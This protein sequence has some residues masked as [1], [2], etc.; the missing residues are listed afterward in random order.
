[1]NTVT[2]RDRASNTMSAKPNFF[3]LEK[4][5]PSRFNQEPIL[6]YNVSVAIS[7]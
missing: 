3:S 6:F 4:L 1:M 5:S 2:D 7:D